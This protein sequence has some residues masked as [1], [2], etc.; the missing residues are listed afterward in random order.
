MMGDWAEKQ[1][2]PGIYGKMHSLSKAHDTAGSINNFAEL[3]VV[4]SFPG[5]LSFI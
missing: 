3:L 2:K 5:Y 4:Q 1:T